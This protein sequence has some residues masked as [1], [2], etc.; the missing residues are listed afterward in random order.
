MKQTKYFVF[1]LFLI[2]IATVSADTNSNWVRPVF[3]GGSGNITYFYNY[4]IY[5]YNLTYNVTN[6][7]IVINNITNQ[8]TVLNNITNHYE[9]TTINNTIVIYNITNI[10]NNYNITI[11][12]NATS[13][14]TYDNDTIASEMDKI[15]QTQIRDN[16]TISGWLGVLIDWFNTV[17]G[18]VNT[19]NETIMLDNTTH[20][21]NNKSI[22]LELDTIR[23]SING[24][25]DNISDN[26][27]A[28]NS[29][30]TIAYQSQNVQFYN[31]TLIK[32][33][34]DAYSGNKFCYENGVMVVRG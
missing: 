32:C 12:S 33:F 29:C 4:T 19:I 31:V 8:T 13:N 25:N 30:P 26:C 7:T 15:R 3:Y 18:R 16:S 2:L 17:S 14:N 24:V 21:L 22:S 27:N 23:S 20:T 1:L 9:Y 28:T 6:N 10:T 5:I 11:Y 34:N